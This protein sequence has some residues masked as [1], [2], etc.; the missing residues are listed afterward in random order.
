IMRATLSSFQTPVSMSHSGGFTGSVSGRCVSM[1]DAIAHV[2][3]TILERPAFDQLEV[4]LAAHGVEERHAGAEQDGMDGETD[5]VD[6][7]RLEQRPGQFAAA[8]E[9]DALAGLP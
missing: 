6:E 9:A 8:H 7:V 4:D 3:T 2:D 5:L 1:L